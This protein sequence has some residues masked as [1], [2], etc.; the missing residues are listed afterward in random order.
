[1]DT[2]NRLMVAKNSSTPAPATTYGLALSNTYL[3][4]LRYKYNPGSS[5]DDSVDLWLNP[6]S[7]GNDA[8]MPAP[9]LSTTNNNDVAAFGS[10]AY[11]QEIAVANN[12]VGLYFI[13][14]IRVATNWAGVT[15]TNCSPGATFNVT[16]GGMVCAGT[17]FPVGLQGSETGVDYLL[18]LNGVFTG[19]TVSGT[20]QAITF[21]TQITSGLYTVLA[22]N[23]STSCVGWMNGSASVALLAA[24]AIVTQPTGM[25][26]AAGGAGTFSVVATGDGLTYQWRRN[27]VNLTDGGHFAGTTTPDLTIYP[28]DHSDVATDQN[29]YDVV[30]TGTCNPPATSA[31]VGLT[32]KATA[33]LVWMGDGA[34][35]V[36]DVATTA[37]WNDNTSRF[38][39]GDNVTFD[40]TSFNTAVA[41]GHRFLSPG[42]IKVSGSQAYA[43]MPSGGRISGPGTRL[44]MEGLGSLV[45]TNANTFGGG[46]TISNG[47]ISINNASS[48]GSGDITLAGGTLDVL[49]VQITLGNAINVVA[50]STIAVHNTS[51]SALQLDGS[52]SG[53]GGMLTFK[54]ATAAGP[55]I[56]L[57]ST[58]LTFDRPLD[59]HLGDLGGTRLLLACYNASGSQTFNGVISGGGSIERRTTSS[60]TSGDTILNGNNTYSGGTLLR[61]G[62]LGLGSSSVMTAPP[63]VDSGPLGTGTLT[64]D[65]NRATSMRLFAWG[66]AQ[67]V[68]N[69]IAYLGLDIG[70]PLIITGTNDLTLSGMIDLSGATRTFQV[71][72]TGKTIFS[73]DIFNGGLIK[74]GSGALYLNGHVSS[75]EPV[76]VASGTLGGTGVISGPAMIVAEGATLAPGGSVGTLTLNGNLAVEVNK[77]LSPSS[78]TVTVSGVLTN[79]GNGTVTVANLGPALAVGDIFTVFSQPLTRGA[80]LTVSGGGA[81]WVNDLALDGSLKVASLGPPPRP[82]ITATILSGNNLIFSGTN[83]TATAGGNYYVLSAADVALP[84]AN[85]TRESTNVFGP[86]GTFSVTTSVTA[87]GSRKFYVLQVP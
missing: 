80:A 41:M 34:A 72:N 65:T 74:T 47:T 79:G 64:V 42:L 68:A 1:M 83:G 10:V 4:V 84:L 48:L 24:P 87:G 11:F 82:V 33:N 50:D 46:T 19:T 75:I 25:P 70:L 13:D 29:G 77:S 6:T 44:L 78:D 85:W 20:G 67:T 66:G 40:D 15:P 36:W 81:T 73:G 38:F 21:G 55:T 16:G 26:V 32:V 27:G 3:L 9:T 14:E 23:S 51:T 54:N 45:I 18:Y 31:R 59:L 37:N 28:A 43:F 60:T 12:G 35:N 22:S 56:R 57:T 30:I 17:G 39:F 8:M 71:D 49:N 86:G 61:E 58:N 5:S 7:L 53:T 69:P 62:G 76:V 2:Q 63:T 52:L